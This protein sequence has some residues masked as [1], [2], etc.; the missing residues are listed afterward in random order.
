MKK[1]NEML[2]DT[3]PHAS[4][5]RLLSLDFFRG[6]TMFLL[7]GKSTNL[8]HLLQVS[9]IGVLSSL[10]LQ[11]EHHPWNGLTFW[12][13]VEPFFMFIVG[14]A[15][16]FSALKRLEK[17]D[18]WKKIFAHALQRS[19]TLFLLGIIYY[20]I[21][22][23]KPVFKLW[24]VL[25]QLGFTYL[26]AFLL[27]R[28]PI[29]VQVSV[30]FGLLFLSELLY[31]FWPL[32]GFNQAFVQ[33][34]NFGTWVD[35][36]LMGMTE[37]GYWVAFNAVPTAAFTIWGVVAGLILRSERT[38]SQKLKILVIAGLAGIVLGFALNPITPI[39]KRIATSS[40]VIETG[41]WCFVALAF[42]YWMVDLK[43]IQRVPQFFAIVGMN[44]LFIYL[45]EQFGGVPYLIRIVK[46]FTYGLF[47]WSSET[48]LPYATALATWFLL[49]YMCYWLYKN[50]ILIKI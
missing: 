6:L 2:E 39:I 29:K 19:I 3:K 43:K 31:R 27:M 44:C 21:S 46:P 5:Q 37:K 9:G 41:G 7:I 8:Y 34:Q 23:G 13:F 38:A 15:I 47:F 10:G 40:Y 17:G 1:E 49:W 11:F 36:Q 32:E 30:S 35:L 48:V 22:A 20:S 33:A 16:P 25:T 24:N 12:D 18:P 26:I 42:S 14:V 4:A 28:K 45:F 50:K